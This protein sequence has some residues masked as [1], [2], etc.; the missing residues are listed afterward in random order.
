MD[1]SATTPA[2]SSTVLS[3]SYLVD[4]LVGGTK[5]GAQTG[6]GAALTY[7]FAGVGGAPVFADS[8]YSPYSS[9]EEP[10]SAIHAFTPAQQAATAAALGAWSAVAN[11]SFAQ[12]ADGA[13]GAGDLRLAFSS[14]PYQDAWGWAYSPSQSASA[15]DVWVN[16]GGVAAKEDA[17]AP[18]GVNYEELLHELGHAIGLKHPFDGPS[19]LPPA[20]D[21]VNHSVMSYRP[22]P[23]DIFFRTI[24][25]PDGHQT[26]VIE[27]VMPDTPML[28]DIAAAQYLYGA[29]MSY[30][31]G[32]DVYAFDPH[33][34]FFRTIW[35]AGGNDTL[36]VANFSE[37]C[38]LD[39]RDG[40]YSSIHLH[41]DPL[42]PG[43][44][45]YYSPTYD[46]TDNLAIAYGVTIEN[47]VGGAGNDAIIGNGANNG[48]TGGG[49]N[50]SIDGGA[51][52]DTAFY[53]GD[54]AAYAVG[55]TAG[56]L[57][58]TDA[59]GIDGSDVLTNVERLRFAD[60]GLAFDLAGNAGLVAE[61]L[62]A[63]F[64]RDALSN[65]EYAGI[66]LGVLD[67]GMTAGE[68]MVLAIDTRLGATAS[69]TDVVKLLCANVFAAAPDSATQA[70]YIELLDANTYTVAQFGLLAAASDANRA[71]IDMVGL[72]STGLA[73]SD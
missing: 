37:G 51:G 5:W 27:T 70:H 15:G 25:L 1:L 6:S 7:S 11:L 57:T 8:L 23:H 53:S 58:V 42:P 20:L 63:V 19:T 67:G 21:D 59:R 12:V 36:S 50:D 32:D 38:T 29:N 2:V 60:V 72:A 28:L 54:R 34:P 35:D 49:G 71:N 18:G 26:S 40:H 13:A 24:T 30:R 16:Y 4:A 44:I 3:G 9:L 69:H 41:S 22:A 14:V 47:A 55:T 39:L 33:Q 64:G 52:L 66:G 61:T 46:G 65:T 17:W 45:N 48:L 31:T 56:G 62:G 43:S 73:Y 10:G 68:L